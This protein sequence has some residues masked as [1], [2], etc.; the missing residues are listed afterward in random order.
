M[1]VPFVTTHHKIHIAQLWRL[2]EGGRPY[3]KE[4]IFRIVRD[5]AAS[6]A[7]PE[8][9]EF[10]ISIPAAGTELL[11]SAWEAK[12]ASLPIGKIIAAS[13]ENRVLTDFFRT[14]RYVPDTEPKKTAIPLLDCGEFP[15]LGRL[16]AIPEMQRREAFAAFSISERRSRNMREKVEEAFGVHL[17]LSTAAAYVALQDHRCMTADGLHAIILELEAE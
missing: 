1:N 11:F 14:G 6:G 9:T 13:N 5:A 17:P 16:A 12:Q 7:F 4:L 8:G 2:P 15:A 3:T 10:N